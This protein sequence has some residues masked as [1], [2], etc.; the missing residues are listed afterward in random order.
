MTLEERL[1]PVRVIRRAPAPEAL[2]AIRNGKKFIVVD[3]E[4]PHDAVPLGY[5]IVDMRY[6][7]ESFRALVP[8][9]LLFFLAN[10]GEGDTD[11]ALDEITDFYREI[12][13]D[14]DDRLE[15]NGT[16]VQGT[17]WAVS[18]RNAYNTYLVNK[19]TQGVQ[20]DP[21]APAW[22]RETIARL[23]LDDEYVA[24]R[25]RAIAALCLGKTQEADLRKYNVGDVVR[26][27]TINERRVENLSREEFNHVT[28]WAG[29]HYEIKEEY[30]RDPNVEYR[31]D[32]VHDTNHKIGQKITKRRDVA[33]LDATIA[34]IEAEIAAH[35]QMLH[36]SLGLHDRNLIR[37][38]ANIVHIAPEDPL[39][40]L[41]T[42]PPTENWG[43]TK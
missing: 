11:N 38:Y 18:A 8:Q 34:G 10:P 22:N 27:V 4:F 2:E 25:V 14:E 36:G 32:R 42:K 31:I 1:R 40:Q 26:H 29:S 41:E 20:G 3:S 16:S 30:R 6:R 21:N 37:T 15:E 13:D 9:R 17:N 12:E 5:M 28:C 35:R 39:H 33:V 43:D 23:D 7:S 19:L 24:R